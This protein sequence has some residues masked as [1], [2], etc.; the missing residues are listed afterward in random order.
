MRPPTDHNAHQHIP[1]VYDFIWADRNRLVPTISENLHERDALQAHFKGK[2]VLRTVADADDF[3]RYLG[4]IRNAAQ[5]LVETHSSSILPAHKRPLPAGAS[6]GNHKGRFSSERYASSS[7]PPNPI[8]SSRPSPL[9][10]AFSSPSTSSSSLRTPNYTPP[11]IARPAPQRKEKEGAYYTT[12]YEDLPALKKL[13]QAH[14]MSR[15]EIASLPDYQ[16]TFAMQKRQA[17]LSCSLPPAVAQ[18]TSFAETSIAEHSY[19]LPMSPHRSLLLAALLGRIGDVET[20]AEK[21]ASPEGPGA[22]QDERW[23]AL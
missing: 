4:L 6:W 9:S 10:S 2:G 12:I 8:G 22:R 19:P 15:E 21:S 20:A 1:G 17:W 3:C 5:P 13:E 11:P 23:G 16:R 14:L 7:T 18:S